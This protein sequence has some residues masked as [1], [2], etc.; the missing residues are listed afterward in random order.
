MTY[1]KPKGVRYVDMCMYIDENVYKED[2]DDELIFQYLYHISLMIARKRRFF[3]KSRDLDEYALSFASKVFMR[4]RNPKQFQVDENGQPLLKPIKS[5][6]NYMKRISYGFKVD[7]E[8][9]FYSQ[10]LITIDDFQLNIPFC[11]YV[12]SSTDDLVTADYNLYLRDI[13]K[14]IKECVKKT[15][16]C[17]NRELSHNLY[18]SILLSLL[19]AITLSNSSKKLINTVGSNIYS[20]P[21]ILERIYKDEAQNCIILY[22]LPSKYKDYLRVLLNEVKHV[23]VRDLSLIEHASFN[24]H[25]E[26]KNILL[27]SLTG[28]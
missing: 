12:S 18:I 26:L 8:Q 27:K 16:Y 23:V 20:R 13:P 25:E 3:L 2:C 15:P 14:T 6:L 24:A 28:E 19:S 17:N 4:L 21:D 11:S 10:K 22:H 5:V 7:F 9:E 1:N